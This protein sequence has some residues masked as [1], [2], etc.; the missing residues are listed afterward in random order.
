MCLRFGYTIVEGVETVRD[1]KR[2]LLRSK[3][4]VHRNNFR[5]QRLYILWVSMEL[6]KREEWRS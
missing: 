2:T 3:R 4:E 6:I 1:Q 5:Y